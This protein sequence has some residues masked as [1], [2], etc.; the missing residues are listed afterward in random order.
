[1][2]RRSVV[3][4]SP[5]RRQLAAAILTTVLVMTSAVPVWAGEVSDSTEIDIVVRPSGVTPIPAP[6]PTPVPGMP[7][8]TPDPVNVPIL[9]VPPVP[10]VLGAMQAPAPGTVSAQVALV[11]PHGASKRTDDAVMT[12]VVRDDR[13][14]AAGWDVG[15]ASAA[16]D[17][18]WWV[19]T[20][21]EN[22]PDTIRRLVPVG[23]EVG[24]IAGGRI[25]GAYE[26]PVPLVIAAPGSGSGVY[27]QPL[28]GVIPLIEDHATQGQMFVLVTFAP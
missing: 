2:T 9:L 22:R 13:G 7:A 8:P 26:N 14:T 11:E 21:L 3:R 23:G 24:D 10:P 28:V 18:Y 19:P 16:P 5:R 12:L 4:T 27:S 25:L 1:M 6:R 17:G 20:L 15:M